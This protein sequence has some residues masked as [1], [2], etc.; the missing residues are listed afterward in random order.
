MIVINIINSCS[1]Y[2]AFHL[3]FSQNLNNWFDLKI[4]SKPKIYGSMFK[5]SLGNW[6]IW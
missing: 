3:E 4:Y 5:L 2:L 6:W 1:K